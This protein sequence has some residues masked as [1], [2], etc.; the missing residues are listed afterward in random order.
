M[1][2][3]LSKIKVPVPDMKIPGLEFAT[4]L[5]ETLFSSVTGTLDTGVG[6][7]RSTIGGI[8]FFGKNAVSNSY[9]HEQYDERHYF[10]IPDPDDPEKFSFCITRCLPKGVPPINDLEK[11][12]LLHLPSEHGLP[13]LRTLLLQEAEHSIR[14]EA[15]EPGAILKSLNDLL[16]EVDKHDEKAF[17]GLLLIGGLVALANPLAG[18]AVAANAAVPAIATIVSKYG[19][20]LANKKR[21]NMEIARNIK[22][23]E[24]DLKKQFRAAGTSMVINPILL[25]FGH[26]IT[27]E[28]WLMENNQFAFQCEDFEFSQA[29]ITRFMD[30]TRDA[31]E[32]TYDRRM[33]DA[34]FK[35]I[36]EKVLWGRP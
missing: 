29:D 21:T 16:D 30:L 12:R 7:L 22:K 35:D 20:K 17:A 36:R 1:K 28:S 6:L 23:A 31:I 19:L 27:I 18:A 25:N 15:E 24:K 4:D 8:P 34:Y 13:M 10:L 33:D 9:D 26:S 32:D 11:R 2:K 5:G 14:E 3:L